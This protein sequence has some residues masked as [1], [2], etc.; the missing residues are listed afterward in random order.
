MSFTPFA[1]E[2][3]R[4]GRSV[5]PRA[6]RIRPRS[7]SSRIPP[8]RRTITCSRSG[9]PGRS[10]ISTRTCRSSTAASTS[11]RTARSIDEPAQMLLI[12]NDPELQR[13]AGRG[14]SCRTSGST[15]STSRKQLD[16]AGQRRQAVAASAGGNAVRPGRHVEPLQARELSQRRR[17]GGQGDGDVSPA[18]TIRGRASMPSPA[19][20]T[21]CRSTGTTRAA[22]PGLYDNGD[23]HAVRILAMEPTTD[24]Q[25]GAKAGRLF[26]SHA[27]ERLRILGEIPVRKFDGDKQPLDPD[28]NP[29]TSFLA[30]IPADIAFTF[31]TLDKD[32]MVLNMAQ[33]WHQLR[34]GEIRTRLR[35]L[36]RPQ[37]EAD[38]SSSDTLAA[39]ARLQGLR[40]D[41]RRRRSLTDEGAATNRSRSGTPTTRPACATSKAGVQRRVPPR[42]PA[43]PRAQLRRLPHA[44]D[45]DEPA[46]NL[47][48]D[49]DDEADPA[50]STTASSPART[51][52][53]ALDERAKFGHKPVGYDSLGLSATPRATS[54]SSR[55]AAACSSGRSSASASTASRTTIIRP[56]RSPARETSCIS[57]ETG[58][59]AEATRTAWTS[60]SPAASMPPPDAVKAGKVAAAHRRRPPHDRPLDRPRLPDRPRLRPAAARASAATAGCSTTIG[61][62]SRSRCRRSIRPS[63]STAS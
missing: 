4:P 17:A 38:A 31:Q 27:N 52:R 2:R 19:T 58:R 18:A 6:T 22:T 29:D 26:H 11:S 20:A 28:G 57:G 15:A 47:V 13:A 49:A 8:A 44:Q 25:R 62:S 43:D 5:G 1:T 45:G 63:R 50:S 42:H 12:K 60:T 35:R 34:P 3:R 61:P 32:G 9:R 21:A 23:I 59:P 39:Q 37:P 36:P 54:A 33:T 48:L 30:K 46:G 55:R 51:I 16:A 40:P 7:A 24:R 56:N 53:L 14:P 10:T 41:R